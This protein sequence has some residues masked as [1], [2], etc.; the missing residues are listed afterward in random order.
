MITAE[1]LFHTRV[2][3]DADVATCQTVAVIAAVAA[4][5]G[6]V[7]V[8][9]R[10]FRGR[11]ALHFPHTRRAHPRIPIEAT[12]RQLLNSL[13]YAADHLHLV[14][15][16][17]PP[18]GSLTGQPIAVY[19]AR[20][21]AAGPAHPSVLAQP[22]TRAEVA[23]MDLRPAQLVELAVR[24]GATP[25]EMVGHLAQQRHGISSTGADR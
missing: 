18:A 15:V 7:L 12:V 2:L 22:L 19:A 20:V 8:R 25:L 4:D 23:A 11:P 9:R 10:D 16:A 1:M 5:E 24:A 14:D 21:V 13:G 3:T 6:L 17:P